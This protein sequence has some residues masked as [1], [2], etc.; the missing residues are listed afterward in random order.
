MPVKGVLN[1]TNTRLDEFWASVAASLPFLAMAAA[2]FL[3]FAVLAVLLARFMRKVGKN[4]KWDPNLQVFYPRLARWLIL[5]FGA[6]SALTIAVPGFT[7]SSVIAGLGFG[8]VAIGFAFRDLLENYF[9]GVYLLVSRPFRIGQWIKIDNVSG[10]VE[11]ITTRSVHVRRMDRELEILPCSYLFKNRF[12]VVDNSSV[13][14]FEA[15]L[16]VAFNAPL[17]DV[18]NQIEGVVKD[19]PGV[20]EDPAPFVVAESIAESG[21]NLRLY[22]FLNTAVENTFAA[23]HR[24]TTTLHSTL[25]PLGVLVSNINV[26]PLENPPG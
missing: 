13:R 10:V 11:A 5:I 23:R 26:Q 15:T 21:V 20:V 12:T 6:A 22:Y 24:I 19:M 3:F 17:Q 1:Q 25:R 2:V 4:R 14:R 9:A 18:C 8:S 16:V 7:M